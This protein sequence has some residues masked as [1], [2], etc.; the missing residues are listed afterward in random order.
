M[1]RIV[2]EIDMLTEAFLPPKTHGLITVLIREYID[3]IG[4]LRLFIWLVFATD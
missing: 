2:A 3:D 1:Y 4:L